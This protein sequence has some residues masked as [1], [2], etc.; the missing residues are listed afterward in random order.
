MDTLLKL[1]DSIKVDSCLT[2]WTSISLSRS[3]LHGVNWYF[4]IE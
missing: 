2:T 3:L 1:S 4:W